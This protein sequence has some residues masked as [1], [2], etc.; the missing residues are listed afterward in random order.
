MNV[1]LQ[2]ADGH[3]LSAYAAEPPGQPRGGVII[4]QEIFGV[5]AHIRA[6]ADDYAAQ[7]YRVLAPAFFDRVRPNVELPYTDAGREEGRAVVAGVSFED[8]VLD[9]TAA[10]A[11]LAGAGNIGIVGYCWGGMAGWAAV[12]RVDGFAALSAYYPGR[13][14]ELVADIPRCPVQLHFAEHDHALGPAEI[15]T[16]R[17]AHGSRAE[18]F[19]YPAAHG[20]NCNLRPV[21]DAPSAALA[22]ERTLRLLSDNLG[23]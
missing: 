10:Q 4:I 14:H 8:A 7:G 11:A 19:V 15:E 1:T 20:F 9:V 6:V 21:Y 22:R 12:T 13:I 17:R 3:E 23:R 16:M 5:N 18:I 2:A